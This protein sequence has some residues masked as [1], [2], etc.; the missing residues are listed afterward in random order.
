MKYYVWL[1][2]SPDYADT[3]ELSPNSTTVEFVTDSRARAVLS[4]VFKTVRAL[5]G[6]ISTKP[7]SINRMKKYRLRDRYTLVEM[8]A[9][10]LENQLRSSADCWADCKDKGDRPMS[11]STHQSISNRYMSAWF[12]LLDTT[13]KLDLTIPAGGVKV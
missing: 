1:Q 8:T 2:P 11:A 12:A 4:G 6:P 9:E 13:G 10:E 5:E 3:G 7:G